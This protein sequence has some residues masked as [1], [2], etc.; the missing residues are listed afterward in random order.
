MSHANM[1]L[2][3]AIDLKGGRCV[4]LI[5]GRDERTTIYGDDPVA[6]AAEWVR[7]GASWLHIVNLDGA[8]GRASD[9]LTIVRHIIETTGAS[10]EF[11]GGLRTEEAVAVAF[12]LG[13]RKV[14]LGTLAF[15]NPAVLARLLHRHG[16]DRLIVAFDAVNGVIAAKGWTE[17][18]GRAVMEGA[19]TMEAAGMCEIL[20][21]DVSRDGMLTG[22]DLVTLQALAA[23][24]KLG[25]IA[26]G[27]VAS[28]RDISGL[29]KLRLSGIIVGK[30]LYERVFTVTEALRVLEEAGEKVEGTRLGASNAS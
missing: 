7:Q 17:S 9:N 24:T 4:R 25:I 6:V 18:T 19:A 16:G 11:G 2:L 27:G 29:V 28:L 30:A 12:S 26:S 8:F 13:V 21:T 14:V 15:E 3:P 1:R 10:V 20:Y 5:Q 23:G 22:P